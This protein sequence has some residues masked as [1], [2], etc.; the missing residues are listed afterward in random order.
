MDIFAYISLGLCGL[1]LIPWVVGMLWGMVRDP[2]G[3]AIVLMCAVPLLLICGGVS[4]VWLI[5]TK[6]I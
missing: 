6:L 1:L 2:P 4:A 5:G 3:R